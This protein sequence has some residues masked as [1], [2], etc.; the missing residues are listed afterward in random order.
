MEPIEINHVCLQTAET[1]LKV[2]PDL[3]WGEPGDMHGREQRMGALRTHDDVFSDVSNFQS[4]P[5]ESFT[6]A[7]ATGNPGTVD[8]CGI[9]ERAPVLEKGVQEVKS[10]GG[11]Y[12]GSKR[13]SPQSEE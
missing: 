9:N 12:I 6:Q 10:G 2:R 13:A 8:M 1:L 11:V 5:N 7:Q 4:V 3:L